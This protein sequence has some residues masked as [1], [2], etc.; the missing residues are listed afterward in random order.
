MLDQDPTAHGWDEDQVWTGARVAALIGRTFHISYSVSGATRLMHRLGFTPQ[1]PARRAA[2]RDEQAITAWKEDTWPEVKGPGRPPAAGS[3]SR[4]KPA[5]S[6]GRPP[7]ALPQAPPGGAPRG[8]RGRTP[9]VTVPGRRSGRISLAG[10]IALRPGSRTRLCY[11][12]RVHH[13]RRGERRSLSE[14][15]YM[16]LLDGTHQLLRVPIVL[17]WDRLGTHVSKTMRQLVAARPWL[18]V[19]LLPAYAPEL[20]PV[21]GVWAHCRHRLANLTAGTVGRLETLVR[22]R[23]KRLQYRPVTLH[24]FMTET[25]LQ[26]D[27]PPS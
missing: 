1:M 23:L 12:I 11:R 21:E 10:L 13:G 2:E 4:T 8:R 24:G 5:G 6:S 17:V 18:T 16:R 27:S 7:S 19:F 9:V 20:N 26:L 15:D 22:N 25:G 14:A 3:A